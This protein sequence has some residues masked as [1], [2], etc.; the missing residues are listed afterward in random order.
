MMVAKEFREITLTLLGSGPLRSALEGQVVDSGFQNRIHFVEWS[1]DVSGVMAMHDVL[2]LASDHEGWGM[3][4]L[5]AAAAGMPIVTTDVGCA[6][7]CVRDSENGFVV[8]VGDN[9]HYSDALRR[10]VAETGLV[11]VHGQRS[12]EIAQ[13]ISQ[14]EVDY[15]QKLVDSYTLCS[16]Q[17]T[18]ILPSNGRS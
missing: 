7:E 15:T 3:V 5:E 11:T 9:E 13:G 12:R 6:G 10:Y 2:C 4:M 8:K 1:D 17:N 14:K 16:N 18:D